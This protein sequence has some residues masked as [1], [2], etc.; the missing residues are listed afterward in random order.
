MD[1]TETFAINV[2][3]QTDLITN[4]STTIY[5]YSDQSP[6]ALKDM[7]NEFFKA[8]GINHKCEDIFSMV[9]LPEYLDDRLVDYI[10]DNYDNDDG[11][12]DEPDLYDEEDSDYEPKGEIICDIPKKF[13]N[14]KTC[15]D[16]VSDLINDIKT[17][18]QES[19]EWLSK[20]AK[21]MTDDDRSY[22]SGGG[23][24]LYI[25]AK[26]PKHH[27]LAKMVHKFLYSTNHE[28]CQDG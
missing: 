16:V 26:D 18:K 12:D 17:G 11:S 2:H 20:I 7:V 5:T 9:V 14:P 10:L 23:S 22:G 27:K 24:M 1:T 15:C 6:K 4:S 28:G 21:E 19:P 25:T 8:F 13:R 3:S